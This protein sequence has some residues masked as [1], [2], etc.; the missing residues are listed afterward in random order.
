MSTLFV[1]R[2]VAVL[3]GSLIVCTTVIV[4]QRWHGRLSLDHDL[5]GVQKLHGAPVPRI[6]GLGLLSGLI[7]A[8]IMGHLTQSASYPAMLWLLISAMPAFLS[9]LVEDLTKKVRVRTRLLASFISAG[10]A[11]WLLD[12]RLLE[13]NTPILDTLISYPIISVLFTIFAVAGVTHSIN[14]IDGLNGLA[15]GTVSIIL[16][17]LAA[18]SWANG[19]LMVMT[20]CLWG[21]AAMMGFL[22]LNFPFGRIFLGDGGAYL[23]GFWV[24]EC[25]VLLLVRNPHVSTWAVLLT[26]FYPVWETV[27]SMYRRRMVEHVYT[28]QPDSE[29][30]HQLFYKNLQM[31]IPR[32][33]SPDWM[34]HG[35]SSG[36]IWG[37][38]AACQI[39]AITA[40]SN[41][42]LIFCIGFFAACYCWLYRALASKV[43][44]PAGTMNAAKVQTLGN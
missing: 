1:W 11:V 4:T 22:A 39:V 18:L 17:G 3:L 44:Y 42:T 31:A 16:T 36:L 43:D 19:D 40:E 10:L 23:A 35:I 32:R 27:Y 25:G 21:V 37:I 20:L 33:A 29:H 38:T 15:A 14:I 2:L 7:V 41:L 6:G 12:A 26:C 5:A 13:V 30:L 9:G 24:A 34:R 8:V 28:G